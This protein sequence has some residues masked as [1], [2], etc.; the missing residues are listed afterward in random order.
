MFDGC[1]LN[2]WQ[3]TTTND[4]SVCVSVA[5]HDDS[6]MWCLLSLITFLCKKKYLSS[7]E[8]HDWIS[9]LNTTTTDIDYNLSPSTHIDLFMSNLLIVLLYIDWIYFNIFLSFLLSCV[10]IVVHV[11]HIYLFRVSG[12]EFCIFHFERWCSTRCDTCLQ[13]RNHHVMW[14]RFN[15]Y[16]ENC[17]DTKCGY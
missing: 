1:M 11:P 8:Q 17:N 10:H 13:S 2:E 7:M 6:L 5:N 4:T 14:M 16:T 9:I 15:W 3:Q 12:I